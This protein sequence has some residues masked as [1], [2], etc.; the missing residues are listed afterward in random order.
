MCN[1]MQDGPLLSLSV[2]KLDLIACC[3]GWPVAGL[4]KIDL[5]VER[6]PAIFGC[7]EELATAYGQVSIPISSIVAA[8]ITAMFARHEVSHYGQ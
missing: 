8:I 5:R 7:L 3:F 4:P 2:C 1:F 6:R